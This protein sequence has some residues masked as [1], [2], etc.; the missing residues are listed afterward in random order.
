MVQRRTS[1]DTWFRRGA[2]A[3][4]LLGVVGGALALLTPT[5]SMSFGTSRRPVGPGTIPLIVLVMILGLSALV[6][7]IET[8]RAL[9]AWKGN[10]PTQVANPEDE[11]PSGEPS[12][13]R[14]VAHAAGIFGALVIF[15]PI[16]QLTSFPVA[17]SILVVVLSL[18]LQGPFW[19]QP[20]KAAHAVLA[21]VLITLGV[22]GLFEYAL[23]IRLR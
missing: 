8:V 21:S 9:K 7:I 11:L 14:Q 16:W 4:L 18:A 19:R 17:G 6:L 3:L 13:R 2:F 10:A 5:L 12:V 1:A 23:D 15:L 20:R 22:W